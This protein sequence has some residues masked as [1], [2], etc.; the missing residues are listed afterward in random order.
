MRFSEPPPNFFGAWNFLE[1]PM[2]P[3]SPHDKI[4]TP[5]T[6]HRFIDMRPTT[7]IPTR[8][9]ED[10]GWRRFK[11]LLPSRAKPASSRDVD[12]LDV[13]QSHKTAGSHRR[14][15]IQEESD[16]SR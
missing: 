13:S 9:E 1:A 3:A 16:S 4:V 8:G 10:D 7:H 11:F 14:H 5:P 12:R 2:T 6:G 15:R